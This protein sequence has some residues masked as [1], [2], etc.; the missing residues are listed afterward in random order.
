MFWR[1]SR[2]YR[3][4]VTVLIVS[5]LVVTFI[6]TYIPLLYRDLINLLTSANAHNNLALAIHV[7]VLVLIANIARIVFWRVMNF[8]NNFFQARVM[9]NLMNTCYQYLQQHSYGFFTSNFVGSL[10]TKVKRFE[11]AFEQITDQLVFDLGRSFLDT[12]MILFVL[13]WQYRTFGLIMTAWCAA[14]L[15][16]V[17][18]F[19]RFRLQYDIRRA[20]ADTR[21]TG[22]LA[23]TI[24]NNVNIKSF[25]QYP[26]EYERFSKVIDEQFRARKKSWDM[27]TV[28]DIIQSIFMI[29]AEFFVMYF[30]VIMWSRG[31]LM[32]GDIALLQM[33]LLRIFDKLWSTG[34]NIR[35][36]YESLADA[37][38]MTELLLQPHGITDSIGA[39][40]LEVEKG[41]INFENVS[42][43]YHDEGAVLNNFKLKI[44]PGERV[45]LIGPSGGGKSTIAK[46]LFRFYDLRAGKILIDGQDIS[47]VTQDSLRGKIALVPQDPILFHRSL[48]ENMRYAKPEA[49]NEEVVEAAKA[50]HAHEFI[51]SFRQGYNTLVGERG[52]KLSGGERQRVAIARAILKKAP[53]LVLDEAT[54]SLDSESEMFI[55]DSLKK[56]MQNR[57]T[58]VIA[59]RLS[60]IMQ[61]DRIVVIENGKIIE[62]GR[63]E[64]LL[65]AQK[66]TYQRL[67]EI[68]AGGFA[69]I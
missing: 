29:I 36:I 37:N 2:K 51:S 67:W 22:Q 31:T 66:G 9:G 48:M 21:T 17:F 65:K 14:V 34:R 38:E 8:V 4:Q 59:H 64:E 19:S 26:F 60:T 16:Y 57:T 30:A 58:I 24:T 39:R 46:L 55:Q 56:L 68:Q 5:I 53:I 10:V 11:R 12:G 3:W 18:I 44:K 25:A 43:G 40:P 42:F 7:V 20:E 50:A 1:H 13:L 45:A 27:G 54:S 28:G 33:Y 63:H 41:E 49:S 15:L 52:I 47:R 23:D 61:M 62:E 6:Q 32:V 69:T 35:N